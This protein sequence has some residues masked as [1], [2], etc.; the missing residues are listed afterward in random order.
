MASAFAQIW[1]TVP[2]DYTPINASNPLIICR[3]RDDGRA[4][5]LRCA[6]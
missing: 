1:H 3:D 4:A 6:S 2:M 5:S